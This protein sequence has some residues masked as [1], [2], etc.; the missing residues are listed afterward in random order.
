VTLSALI[1][2]EAA[3]TLVRLKTK[4]EKWAR[5]RGVPEPV[6]EEL[7]GRAVYHEYRRLMKASTVAEHLEALDAGFPCP[8]CGEPLG[9]RGKWLVCES[10]GAEVVKP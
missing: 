8:M 1:G 7:A 2:Q 9:G 5:R 6:A 3:G 4:T 10:C